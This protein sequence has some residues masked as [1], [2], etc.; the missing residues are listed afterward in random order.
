MAEG[1]RASIELGFDPNNLNA[2]GLFLEA[3]HAAKKGTDVKYNYYPEGNYNHKTHILYDGRREFVELFAKRI[4]E[5][6]LVKSIN[7][8]PIAA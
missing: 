2:Y 8:N 5:S 7:I 3:V 4:R 6:G 1:F